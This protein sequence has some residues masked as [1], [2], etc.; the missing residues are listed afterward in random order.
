[1]T[2]EK[3]NTALRAE[4]VAMLG[5]LFT[6]ANRLD[7]R[8]ILTS[9]HRTAEEQKRL[10]DEGKS[11]L[12]G[13]V[14]KSKHQLWRAVDVCIIDERDNLCWE[15]PDYARLGEYWETIGG[16]WGGRWASLND[17]YHFELGGGA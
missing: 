1:M 16:V 2:A 15:H 3:S 5:L 6:Y 9:V 13:Y 10:F 14:K 4:F 17:I 7:I 11:K 12:D 8:F